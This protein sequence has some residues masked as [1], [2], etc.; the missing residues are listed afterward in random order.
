MAFT[1][2]MPNTPMVI[3]ITRHPITPHLPDEPN[4]GPQTTLE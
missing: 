4:Q 2:D 1:T 3:N